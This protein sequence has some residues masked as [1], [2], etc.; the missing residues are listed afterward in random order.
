MAI[1]GELNIYVDRGASGQNVLRRFCPDC[2]SPM[3]TDTPRAEAQGIIFAKGGT[4]DD[5]ADLVP[6][7]HY[8]TESAQPWMRYPERDNLIERE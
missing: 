7:A 1:E 2:G 8:W 5:V 4:L 3:L 6:T